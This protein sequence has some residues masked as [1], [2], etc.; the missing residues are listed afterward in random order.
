M[1]YVDKAQVILR[2]G[3]FQDPVH[4]N[5]GRI[6]LGMVDSD[7]YTF[8]RQDHADPLRSVSCKLGSRELPLR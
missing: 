6:L 3:T 5:D 2:P 4:V 8:H 1:D 7:D